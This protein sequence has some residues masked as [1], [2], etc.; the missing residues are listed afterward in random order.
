MF[1]NAI[2]V[3]WNSKSQDGTRYLVDMTSMRLV[4]QEIGNQKYGFGTQLFQ[5]KV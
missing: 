4:N 2:H 3:C 5:S 1:H